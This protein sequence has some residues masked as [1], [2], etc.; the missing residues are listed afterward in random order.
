VKRY[1]VKNPD[2]VSRR[3]EKEALLFN[4]SD[5]KMMCIN[6]TGIFIWD[7]SGGDLTVSDMVNKMTD[8]YDVAADKAETDCASYLNDLEKAGFITFKI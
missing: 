2:I 7:M 4:P 3:E 1:P 5:G 8:E 6:G